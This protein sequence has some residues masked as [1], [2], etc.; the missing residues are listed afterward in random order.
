MK[1]L[2]ISIICILSFSSMLK[3]ENEYRFMVNGGFN[4]N[5]GYVIGVSY[6]QTVPFLERQGL[7]AAFDYVQT[8]RKRDGNSAFNPYVVVLSPQYRYS[9][10]ERY[11]FLELI[12]GIP[13]GFSG[14]SDTKS[15]KKD[16][17]FTYGIHAKIT[18]GYH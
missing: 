18:G 9:L 16:L 10:I 4:F 14:Y 15:H 2:L 1:K 13:L 5:R 8:K 3:A 17:R 7:G 12:G 11:F 6:D